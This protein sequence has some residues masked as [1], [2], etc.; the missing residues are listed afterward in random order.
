MKMSNSLNSIFVQIAKYF[1]AWKN[2]TQKKLLIL[3]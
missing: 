2:F 3:K 1:S